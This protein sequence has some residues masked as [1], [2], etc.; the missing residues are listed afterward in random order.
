MVVEEKDGAWV[1]EFQSRSKLRSFLRT[2]IIVISLLFLVGT[3]VGYGYIKYIEKRLH[4]NGDLQET[5]KVISEPVGNEPINTLILGSDARS[6]K[7]NARSDTIIILRINPSSKRVYLVS[8]PR[9]MRVRIPGYGWDKINAANAMGGPQLAVRAVEDFTG[10]TLHH[11]VEV[12]FEGFRKMVDKLGGVIIDVEKPLVDRASKFGIPA[13][14]QL[15]HGERA[16]DYVRFRKDA[17]GDFGRIERQQK[18]FRALIEKSFRLQSVFKLHSLITILA[19]N[20]ETDLTSGEMLAL[21]NLLKSIDE[22]KVQMITLPG[23]VKRVDGRS[24]V[25]PQP[26]V[27]EEIIES[28]ENEHSMKTAAVKGEVIVQRSRLKVT[29]LNGCGTADIARVVAERLSR[30]GFKIVATANAANFDYPKTVIRYRQGRYQEAKGVAKLFIGSVL[31]PLSQGEEGSSD[32][33]V[34]V[35]KDYERRYLPGD[36]AGM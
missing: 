23:E 14:R 8:I 36:K 16:L 13:G 28:V 33:V 30:D 1:K 29:V 25:I 32:V 7:E 3:A 11:Y 20:T 12:N 34:I 21:A 31:E 10:L 2:A 17:Q 18:F 19:D 27:I 9:D 35:G 4:S 15:M 22:K 6:K 24:F 26:E 5:E